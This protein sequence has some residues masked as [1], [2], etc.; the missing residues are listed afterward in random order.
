MTA[1]NFPFAPTHT[2]TRQSISGVSDP[3]VKQIEKHIFIVDR[4]IPLGAI[5]YSKYSSVPSP[6][7]T[8]KS[9]RVGVA[10]SLIPYRLS[11]FNFSNF[12]FVIFSLSLSLCCGLFRAHAGL[13]AC[14][15]LSCLIYVPSA[16]NKFQLS[17]CWDT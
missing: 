3:K 11:L 13:V 8:G 7:P 6:S 2:H 5:N 14:P 9:R 4:K 1:I 10:N 12:L 16:H 15:V 17:R